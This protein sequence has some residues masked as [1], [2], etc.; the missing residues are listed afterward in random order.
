M[1]EQSYLGTLQKSFAPKT[2]NSRCPS[3]ASRTGFCSVR[4][5]LVLVFLDLTGR[6]NCRHRW[7]QNSIWKVK[8]DFL[9]LRSPQR[10]GEWQNLTPSKRG[11]LFKRLNPRDVLGTICPEQRAGCLAKVVPVAGRGD[12]EA[13]GNEAR[14]ETIPTAIRDHSYSD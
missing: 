1:L 3:D 12:T 14:L 9:I 8:P 11:K 6:D 5:C 10:E 7:I 2:A 4:V 13:I